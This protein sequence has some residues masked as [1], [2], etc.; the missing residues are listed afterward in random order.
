MGEVTAISWCDHTFNPSRLG[1]GLRVSPQGRLMRKVWQP[2]QSVIPFRVSNRNS[3]YF[4]KG[5]MW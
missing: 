5:R 3:G 1:C 4:A 2:S